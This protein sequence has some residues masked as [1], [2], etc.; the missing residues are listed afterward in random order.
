MNEQEGR[1][2]GLTRTFFGPADEVWCSFASSL[3]AMIYV[4]NFRLDATLAASIIP[5]LS[6]SVNRGKHPD[7]AE[8]EN[9]GSYAV[10]VGLVA[11]R[12]SGS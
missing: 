12:R 10:Y 3:E 6:N 7:L 8:C 5:S 11:L 9:A 4:K 2:G 1:F